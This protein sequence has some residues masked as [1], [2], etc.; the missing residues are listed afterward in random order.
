MPRSCG[1]MR[2]SAV[3]AVASV[4]TSAAPPIA[5]E[6]RWTRCQS[7]A[8]PS[9]L[10]Y[11]H[12]GETTMRWGSVRPREV[13]VSK[14]LGIGTWNL[15]F[16]IWDL[17]RSRRLS[18][19]RADRFVGERLGRGHRCRAVASQLRR[20]GRQ[21]RDR[22]HASEAAADHR[23]RRAEPVGDR[24][25]LQLAELRAADEEHHVHADHPAA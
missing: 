9:W 14:R 15:G 22:D 17:R 2:P 24:A 11:W 16:G 23:E 20:H 1:L 21:A 7:L 19:R 18:L 10:E 3:T 5:R 12:I 8:N 6:P 25:R 4:I 13:N